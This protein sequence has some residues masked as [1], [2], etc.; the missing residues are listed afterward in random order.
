MIYVENDYEAKL[1][2]M[3]Q[4]YDSKGK[5]YLTIELR[6]DSFVDMA[7]RQFFLGNNRLIV[8]ILNKYDELETQKQ[9]DKIVNKSYIWHFVSYVN[10]Q[11]E[12]FNSPS[13]S[14]QQRYRVIYINVIRKLLDEFNDLED[15]ELGFLKEALEE[16]ENFC[17]IFWRKCVERMLL[18]D[19]EF[20][21]T[22]AMVNIFKGS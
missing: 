18:S 12:R 4:K 17:K 20:I 7:T 21:S 14:G 15:K 3:A 1:T 22:V 16:N 11:N 19:D 2:K 6:N 9:I 10:R 13:I 8:D 5:I